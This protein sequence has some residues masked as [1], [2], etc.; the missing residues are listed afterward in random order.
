MKENMNKGRLICV[1]DWKTILCRYHHKREN[2][3]TT[4]IIDKVYKFRLH[5]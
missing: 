4:C 3:C 5:V 2:I 1:L